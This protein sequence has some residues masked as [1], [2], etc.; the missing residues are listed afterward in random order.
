MNV[1]MIMCHKNIEQVIRFAKRCHTQNTDV[2]IHCDSALSHR[3][4]EAV[5][6]FVANS[7][8]GGG[9]I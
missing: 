2:I 8:E 4:Y 9:T 5:E 3:E 7:M 1:V 6:S